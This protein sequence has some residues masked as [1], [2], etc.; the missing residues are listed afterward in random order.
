MWEPK[1]HLKCTA[2]APHTTST[3]DTDQIGPDADI[4]PGRCHLV[5]EGGETHTDT[6]TH[7]HTHTRTHTHAQT[8]MQQTIRNLLLILAWHDTVL[9]WG[10]Q[11]TLAACISFGA[12]KQ[13]IV[14]LMSFF[15]MQFDAQTCRR[16]TV[17]ICTCV[18][19]I[20]VASR[21]VSSGVPIKPYMFYVGLCWAHV[22]PRWPLLRLCWTYIRPV[23]RHVGPCGAYVG[24][25][26]NLLGL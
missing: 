13:I 2:L 25:M 26:V 8:R 18:S 22:G 12:F 1:R 17:A 24:A 7:T 19:S 20:L 21:S 11:Y 16:F 15:A 10:V 3:P 4:V 23:L 14:F 5:I 6:N 9:L